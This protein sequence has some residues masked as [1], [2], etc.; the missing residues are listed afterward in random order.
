MRVAELKEARGR[1]KSDD[2]GSPQLKQCTVHSPQF[3]S[4]DVC[5]RGV[6]VFGRDC[7]VALRAPRNDRRRT[8]FVHYVT[9]G[10]GFTLDGT[11][12]DGGLDSPVVKDGE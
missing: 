5:A 8:L 4:G 1:R 9:E 6:L 11:P 2:K 12:F 10:D 3:R 7:R